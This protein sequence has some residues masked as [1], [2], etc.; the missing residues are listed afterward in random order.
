MTA[1]SSTS[2]PGPVANIGWTSRFPSAFTILFGLI[3]VMAS[4]TWLIKLRIACTR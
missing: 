2:P 3:V 4:L 1:E